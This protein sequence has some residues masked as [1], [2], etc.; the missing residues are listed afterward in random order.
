MTALIALEGV[1]KSFGSVRATD[2]FSMELADGEAL[3]VIGPNGAGKSTMFN[4]ITGAVRPNA[5]RVLFA[6]RDITRAH[7]RTSAA[8]WGSGAP[9]RSPIP[10]RT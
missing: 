2:Q 4:I 1:S 9:T 10:S 5:G 8:A 6:G 3:G 7:R